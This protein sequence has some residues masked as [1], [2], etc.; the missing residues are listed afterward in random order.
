MSSSGQNPSLHPVPSCLLILVITDAK[1]VTF[2]DVCLLAGLCKKENNGWILIEV[3][4]RM[5]CVAG[6]TELPLDFC[7]PQKGFTLK[8][9]ISSYLYRSS[10]K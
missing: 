6:I 8:L 4:G 10:V 3:C 7:H 2:L 5:A 9:A 1:E